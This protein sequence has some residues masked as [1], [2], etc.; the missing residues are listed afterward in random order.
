MNIN[1]SIL[2]IIIILTTNLLGFLL[3]KSSQPCY[4]SAAAEQQLQRFDIPIQVC[5]DVID[6]IQ[7]GIVDQQFV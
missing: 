6:Q 2:I 4:R 5:N 7:A 1:K 3:C